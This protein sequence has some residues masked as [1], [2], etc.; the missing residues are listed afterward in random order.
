[1]L[2]SFPHFYGADKSLL[3]QIDGLNPR[4]EDHESYLDIHPVSR[5]SIL[6]ITLSQLNIYLTYRNLI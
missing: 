3:E 2:V 6:T 5:Y 4:Q 1:M